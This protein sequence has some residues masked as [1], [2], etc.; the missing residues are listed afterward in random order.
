MGVL[1]K[2]IIRGKMLIFVSLSAKTLYLM[3]DE[4]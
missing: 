4:A 3:M 1:E 2:L